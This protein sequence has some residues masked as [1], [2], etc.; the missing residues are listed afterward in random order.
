MKPQVNAIANRLSLR[1]PQRAAL[2]ILDR[3]CE[4]LPLDKATDV[5]Q[6]RKIIQNEFPSV[7]DFDRDF[8][9]LCFALATGVGKTRLMGAFI[10][11]L[12]LAEGIRHFFVLAPNLTIYNKL[13]ADF[14][15][16]TPK[17]VFA[18]IAEFVTNPPE[19]ITGDNYESGRGVRA[20]D[21]FGEIG[22][23]VNIFNISK[24]NSEVRGGKAPRIKRLSEYIGESYFDYLA[25]LPDLVLIMDESHRYRASAGVRAINE[26][27][28]FTLHR[29]TW[30]KSVPALAS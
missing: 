13:I 19:I 15:P 14:T 3:L 26:L 29:S 20:A 27:K 6:A 2:E 8:P 4:I 25:G 18:G 30:S 11:Y 10:S 9:S 5:A 24:I 7:K 16:N 17:Y 21:L 28:M 12:Y 22:V 23:H 1:A